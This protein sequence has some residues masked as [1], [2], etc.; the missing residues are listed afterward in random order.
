VAKTKEERGCEMRD[1]KEVLAERVQEFILKDM[2]MLLDLDVEDA[3]RW[4]AQRVTA[5]N[6]QVKLYRNGGAPRYF[7][8]QVS[9][10]I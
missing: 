6:T 9:E 4:E 7:T 1:A 5:L 3:V 2:E 8:V 10:N